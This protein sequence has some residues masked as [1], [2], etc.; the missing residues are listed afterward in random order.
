MECNLQAE[1][2]PCVPKLLLV[3]VFVTA[4]EREPGQMQVSDVTTVTPK[5]PLCS[6]KSERHAAHSSQAGGPLEIHSV[7]W[8]EE[9]IRNKQGSED[10][11]RRRPE[12]LPMM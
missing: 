10:K 1:R 9:S 5:D 8:G 11:G 2:N 3:L 7:F 6:A 12:D 4:T